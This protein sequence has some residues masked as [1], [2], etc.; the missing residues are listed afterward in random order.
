MSNNVSSFVAELQRSN[1][2][3]QEQNRIQLQAFFENRLDKIL[4]MQRR[5]NTSQNLSTFIIPTDTISTHNFQSHNIPQRTTTDKH[6]IHVIH[7]SIT[8]SFAKFESKPSSF[9]DNC[10]SWV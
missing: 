2:A 6:L 7:T 8:D 3:A 5:R 9:R 10:P 1:R 4:N